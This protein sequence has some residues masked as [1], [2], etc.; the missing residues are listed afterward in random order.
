M[1]LLLFPPW[2]PIFLPHNTCL[3]PS[4]QP[5]GQESIALF[6]YL[7]LSLDLKQRLKM[8]DISEHT[9]VTFTSPFSLFL[10]ARPLYSRRIMNRLVE[11]IH[12][13][14]KKVYTLFLK[15]SPVSDVSETFICV[16]CSGDFDLCQMFQRL[17]SVS[18]VP[19]TLICVRLS[20]DFDLCHQTQSLDCSHSYFFSVVRIKVTGHETKIHSAHT[21]L[22]LQSE[23]DGM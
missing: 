18:D 13:K 16:R 23:F 12:Q 8:A 6:Q 2:S 10:F 17:W 19:E 14:R 11:A 3:S 15:L 7:I 9:P 20:T 21:H 1:N 4:I 5:W 22:G